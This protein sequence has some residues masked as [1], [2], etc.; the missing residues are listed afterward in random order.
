[1]KGR[2]LIADGRAAICVDVEQTPYA[3]VMLRGPVT[4]S[5]DPAELKHWAT[6]I[7]AR[8][9]GDALAEQYGDRNSTPGE[10]L[11][12]MRVE[13]VTGYAGVAE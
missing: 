12:R 1:V 13:Q 5:E 6:A 8:Y 2:R 9:M 4:I 11:V 3:F 7:A 10:L